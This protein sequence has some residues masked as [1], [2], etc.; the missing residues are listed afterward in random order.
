[1]T[2][3]ELAKLLLT[4]PD[5]PVR[6]MAVG[7]EGDEEMETIPCFEGVQPE[8]HTNLTGKRVVALVGNYEYLER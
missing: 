4:Y 1:M 5:V 2:A 7:V 3:H 8:I 6:V